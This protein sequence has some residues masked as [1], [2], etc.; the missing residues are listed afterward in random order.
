MKRDVHTITLR[1]DF[2]KP[3]KHLGLTGAGVNL[4]SSYIANIVMQI[5]WCMADNFGLSKTFQRQGQ[6][7]HDQYSLSYNIQ[8]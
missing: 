5:R 3:L 2:L 4:I 6:V 1:G 8:C 7:I